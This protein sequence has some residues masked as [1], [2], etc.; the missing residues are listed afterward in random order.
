MISLIGRMWRGLGWL[1]LAP[2]FLGCASAPPP[3][4]NPQ[5]SAYHAP[6]WVM[7]CH[8]VECILEESGR[9]EVARD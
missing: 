3:P 1:L 7:P 5:P 9:E 8:G 6:Q 4:A 2:P